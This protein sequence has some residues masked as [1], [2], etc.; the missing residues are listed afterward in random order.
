MFRF[1]KLWVHGTAALAG[2][3]RI[4]GCLPFVGFWNT[5]SQDDTTASRTGRRGKPGGQFPDHVRC[6]VLST[7]RR[8]LR[9]CLQMSKANPWLNLLS[10]CRPRNRAYKQ[11]LYFFHSFHHH[12]ADQQCL[13]FL[14]LTQP[15]FC[16]HVQLLLRSLP[17]HFV[18]WRSNPP[19]LN[20]LPAEGHSIPSL[21][22]LSQ[23]G[24]PY[25]GASTSQHIRAAVRCAVAL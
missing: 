7:R 22:S 6:V 14:P 5:S 25:N 15:F 19:A 1:V 13:H 24:A 2:L 16:V 23:E 20:S 9:A 18:P 8:F 12:R 17:S 4:T 10:T 3:D 11:D 21:H